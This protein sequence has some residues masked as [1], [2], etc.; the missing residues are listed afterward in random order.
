MKIILIPSLWW[1]HIFPGGTWLHTLHVKRVAITFNYNDY[2][3]MA[4]QCQPRWNLTR[5]CIGLCESME[6]L[7]GPILYR[8]YLE[9]TNWISY[10]ILSTN[11]WNRESDWPKVTQL[12]FILFYKIIML[13]FTWE[14]T[15]QRRR[16]CKT[17]YLK[18][19]YPTIDKLLEIWKAW[20]LGFDHRPAQ[21]FSKATILY[22]SFC[23]L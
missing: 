9:K 8:K 21:Y 13:F 14:R 2:P 17:A 16:D 1:T 18:Q 6:I 3:V 22:C 7:K 5:R 4:F 11:L 19:Q 15:K 20:K 23:S 12:S 10:F